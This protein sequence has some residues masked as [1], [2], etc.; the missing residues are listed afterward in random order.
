MSLIFQSRSKLAF[1]ELDA[2][3]SSEGP[4]MA[5][6]AFAQ[7]VRQSMHVDFSDFIEPRKPYDTI[8]NGC[9]RHRKP[10]EKQENNDI[11]S[12]AVA[13]IL[14]FLLHISPNKRITILLRLLLRSLKKIC[15]MFW[16]I[17]RR[18]LCWKLRIWIRC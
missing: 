4:V 5:S 9:Q 12:V 6:D 16:R 14:F 15:L 13:L 10:Y 8:F 3:T 1:E 18:V 7:F 17:F 11:T 2:I